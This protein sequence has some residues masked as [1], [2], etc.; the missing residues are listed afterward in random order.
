MAGPLSVLWEDPHG[1]AVNKPAG[2]LTQGPADGED[3]VETLVRRHLR[4]DDPAS[5]YVGTV[6]RLDRPVSGVILW[7]K[8]PRAA[9]RWSEQFAGRQAHKEYWAIVEQTAPEL[10][11]RGVWDD[12]LTR[13]D[14][15]GR[16]RVVEPASSGS[17][18]ALTRFEVGDRSR[19]PSGFA[20]LKLRPET[21]RTHQLRA[22]S[23]TRVGSILGDSTYGSR[24][25]FPSGIA[26][27]AR[28]LTIEHPVRRQTITIEA[29]LPESWTSWLSGRSIELP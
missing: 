1:L 15:Q 19:I 6:H 12:W 27:H 17:V 23:S 18:R 11:A 29:P 8:N 5:V 20:W 25:A 7:A 10:E 14:A 4:P 21:G 28:S 16:A 9:R 2:W 24:Q 26:L 22:Q 3:T 13:P